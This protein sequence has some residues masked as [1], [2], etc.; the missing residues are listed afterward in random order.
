MTAFTRNRLEALFEAL[1]D[2]RGDRDAC[3]L[4]DQGMRELRDGAGAIDAYDLQSLARLCIN[5]FDDEVEH[6]Q[7]PKA[8]A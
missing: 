8:V 1:R 2:V 5:R 7:H 4:L 3:R 6:A